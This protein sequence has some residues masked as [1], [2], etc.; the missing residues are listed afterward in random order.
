MS[1]NFDDEAIIGTCDLHPE[2]LKKDICMEECAELIKAISKCERDKQFQE[3]EMAFGPQMTHEHHENEAEEIADVLI[4][5]RMLMYLDT[6]MD[7]EIQWWIDYKTKRQL[8][9]DYQTIRDGKGGDYS[10]HYFM[11]CKEAYDAEKLHAEEGK[12]TISD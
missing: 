1:I 6:H 8:V 2:Y 4:S 7:D 10:G 12:G 9:R 5:I 3:H 11:K